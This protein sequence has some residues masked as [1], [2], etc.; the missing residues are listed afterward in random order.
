M[1]QRSKPRIHSSHL[2]LAL[3]APSPVSAGVRTASTTPSTLRNHQ[4]RVASEG[5][6]RAGLGWKFLSLLADT[7]NVPGHGFGEAVA[8]V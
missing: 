7:A 6:G 3:T 4:P 8:D 2:N 5:G 1:M